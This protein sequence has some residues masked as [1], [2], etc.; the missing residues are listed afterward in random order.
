MDDLE[1]VSRLKG[2]LDPWQIELLLENLKTVTRLGYGDVRL[3][4]VDGRIKFVGFSVS[5]SKKEGE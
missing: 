3:V 2:V 1:I 4:V 5:Y